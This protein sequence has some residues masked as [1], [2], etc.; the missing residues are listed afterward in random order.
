MCAV[1]TALDFD[2]ADTSFALEVPCLEITSPPLESTTP[3][4]LTFN[5]VDKGGVGSWSCQEGTAKVYSNFV[6]EDS[7]QPRFYRKVKFKI[8]L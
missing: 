2:K 4:I 6:R 7:I 8:C 1:L 5:W 3:V